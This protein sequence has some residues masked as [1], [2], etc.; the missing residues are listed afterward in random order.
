MLAYWTTCSGK[1]AENKTICAVLGTVLGEVSSGNQWWREENLHFHSDAL[2]AEAL[3]VK[4]VI[5]LVQYENLDPV[6]WEL[7]PSDQVQNCA[8][9]S[10]DNL[11]VDL[12]S[13]CDHVGDGKLG[14][15]ICELAHGLHN[16]HN[17]SGE[18]SRR[19]KTQSLDLVDRHIDAGKHC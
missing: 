13:L 11:G 7:L 6:D 19:C 16:A 17:L 10:N 5:C 12:L 8:W 4:H 2:L 1:V 15:D 14:L 3:L 18:F 9:S